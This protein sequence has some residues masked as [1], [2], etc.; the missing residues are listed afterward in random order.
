MLKCTVIVY[1]LIFMHIKDVQMIHL[2]YTY[3]Q[4][5]RVYYRCVTWENISVQFVF[6]T[7][8]STNYV[9]QKRRLQKYE[10]LLNKCNGRRYYK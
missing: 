3:V 5:L 9:L 1:S 4:A 2:I 6:R 10:C 8:Y 7:N